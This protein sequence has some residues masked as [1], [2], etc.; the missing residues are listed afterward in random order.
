MKKQKL[1]IPAM[2]EMKQAGRKFVMTT[3]YDYPSAI[4]VDKTDIEAILVGD[5]LGMT[6]LGYDSTVPVTMEE[7]I[8]HIKPVVKGA[9]NSFVVGIYPLAHTIS[10]LRTPSGI[11]PGS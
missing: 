1:T 7:M 9:P 3:A 10:A 8:H 4:L 6:M 2:Q 5:S 11:P